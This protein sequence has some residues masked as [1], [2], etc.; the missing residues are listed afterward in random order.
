MRSR[1]MEAASRY[2][3][4]T[5]NVVSLCGG[6]SRHINGDSW[7]SILQMPKGDSQAIVTSNLIITVTPPFQ[8]AAFSGRADGMLRCLCCVSHSCSQQQWW[9]SYAMLLKGSDMLVQFILRPDPVL[10]SLQ[11]DLDSKMRKAVKQR[12]TEHLHV[13]D[14]PGHQQQPDLD[15]ATQPPGTTI[16]LCLEQNAFCNCTPWLADACKTPAPTAKA[17]PSISR[18]QP[19]MAY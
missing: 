19:R 12:W 3:S 1:S 2:Q 7:Q 14:G 15:T 9:K 13:I 17:C 10:L 11:L 6:A 5:S 18:A 4:C 16:G 8:V